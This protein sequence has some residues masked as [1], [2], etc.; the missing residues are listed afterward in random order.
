MLKNLISVFGLNILRSVVQFFMT[1]ALT[2]FIGPSDYGVMAFVLPFWAFISLVSD[3]GL[4]NAIVRE[5]SLTPQQAGAAAIF[6]FAMTVIGAVVM[7]LLAWPVG[8]L[9]HDPRIGI[10][11]AIFAFIFGIAMTCTIPRA[12]LERELKYRRLA[13]IESCATLGAIPLCLG[14]AV[15]GAGLWSLIAYHLTVQVIRLIGFGHYGRDKIEWTSKWR[16]AVPLAK[17]GGWVLAYNVQNFLAR[18]ADNVIIGFYLGT[19]ALGVYAITYQV[20]TLPLLTVTWPASGVL[21]ATVSRLHNDMPKALQYVESLMSLTAAV[22]FPGMIYLTFGA[23]FPCDA[24]MTPAW[25]EAPGL[26][27]WLAPVG[28]IQSVA[29][30]GGAI[31]T[32]QGKMKLYLSLGVANTV[33]FLVIFLITARIGLLALVIAYSVAAFVGS[34]AYLVALA[35]ALKVP[36]T[37]MF[38]WLL[39]GLFATV[40][41]VAMVLLFRQIDIPADR[42]RWIVDTGVYGVA[43]LLILGF[44]RKRLLGQIAFLASQR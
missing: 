36:L 15:A 27:I 32:A 26:L 11:L 38:S 31:L 19:A 1:L 18:N 34:I 37:R 14:L 4:S 21:L 35:Y 28:A 20:M 23:Q 43:V 16:D 33:A 40:F 42:L 24:Y 7:L 39:T 44:F 3:F 22:I 6:C 29:A 25:H 10:V 41:G 2:R 12:L 30:Y 8:W 17:F 5:K 13:V 9:M